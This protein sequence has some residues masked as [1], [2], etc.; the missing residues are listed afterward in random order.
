MESAKQK[1]KTVVST[2]IQDYPEEFEALKNANDMTR[3]MIRDGD[4][5][6][7]FWA[8]GDA[9]PMYQVAERIQTSIAMMLTP[10]E[11]TWFKSREGGRWFIT[12]F[13]VFSLQN[14]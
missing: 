1:L 5:A 7:A 13:P 6:R 8:G 2:Y 10:D 3:K 12:Q 14:A 9:R 11:L 4:Y